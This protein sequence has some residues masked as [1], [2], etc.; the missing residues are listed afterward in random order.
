VIETDSSYTRLPL[1]E[2][3]EFF[4]QKLNLP[5]RRWTELWQGEHSRAF[6]VAGA[7]KSALI[8]DLREAV[9]KAIASGVTLDEFRRDF[10]KIVNRHGWSYNG[11]RGWRTRVIFDTNVRAAYVAGRYRQMTDPDVLGSRP[12]WEYRHGDSVTPRLLHLSWNGLVLPWDDPW[13]KTHY[14]PNG[15]GCK[16]KVFALSR[17]DMEGIGK[18]EPDDAPDD[19]TYEWKS[20]DGTRSGTIPNGIDPGWDYNVGETAWGRPLAEASMNE[21]RAQKADSWQK[22]VTSGPETYKRPERIP[23]DA[24]RAAIG[25]KETGMDGM[26]AA[27][28]RSIG[29]A[30]KVFDVPGGVPVLVDAATLAAHVDPARS[31]YLPFLD[32]LL[33]DPFEVWLSFEKH[34]G[35]GKVELRARVIKAVA[36]GG[37]DGLLL[38]AQVKGGI[39]EAWTFIPVRDIDYINRQR[40][41]ALLY[42]RK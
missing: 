26:R 25:R 38:V 6:V 23:L 12:Y 8:T 14:P 40:M 37:K 22:L 13:W 33:T 7:M 10:D 11:G 3:V 35:T 21:W 17:R 34:L 28:E 30:E 2:A 4:R 42:G 5:T 36:T 32:E 19:G 20:K 39:L 41:G 1:A 16:C 24:A 9:D 15:W 27:V 18:T 29:G 31:A